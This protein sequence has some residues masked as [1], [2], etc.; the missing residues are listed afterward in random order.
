[1]M[2]TQIVKDNFLLLFS[3]IAVHISAQ[4][5]SSQYDAQTYLMQF[6]PGTTISEI[7]DVMDSMNCVELWVSPITNTRPAD[8]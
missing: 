5:A 2:N 6:E 7:G 3:L 1:M 4:T 8:W